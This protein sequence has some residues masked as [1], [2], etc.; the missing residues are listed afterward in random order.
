VLA[1]LIESGELDRHL[2]RCR[3]RYRR[4]RDRLGEAIASRVPAGRLSGIAAGLHAVLEFPGADLPER[5]LLTHLKERGV[6]VDGITYFYEHATDAPLGLLIGYA[7]PPEHAFT[8]ALEE[9]VGA[10]A[11]VGELGRI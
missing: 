7:T 5:R 10:L 9:L 1:R 6:A 8:G 2:R 11:D 4:R 3:L